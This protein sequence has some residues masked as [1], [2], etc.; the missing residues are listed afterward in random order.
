MGNRVTHPTISGAYG[1]L[2]GSQSFISYYKNNK[3]KSL[4]GAQTINLIPQ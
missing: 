3:E 4:I 1:S 2:S